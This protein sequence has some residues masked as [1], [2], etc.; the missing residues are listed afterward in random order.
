MTP[1]NANVNEFKE[2][3]GELQGNLLLIRHQIKSRQRRIDFSSLQETIT[4]ISTKVLEIEQ[5]HEALNNKGWCPTISKTFYWIAGWQ[6]VDQAAG[7]YD[8]FDEVTKTSEC[9]M[10]LLKFACISDEARLAYCSPDPTPKI[11]TLSIGILASIGTLY[12]SYQS[13]K[14][15]DRLMTSMAKDVRRTS[16]GQERFLSFMESL[17]TFQDQPSRNQFKSSALQLRT[18][19]EDKYLQKLGPIEEL[20][21]SMIAMQDDGDINSQLGKLKKYNSNRIRRRKTRRRGEKGLTKSN[22]FDRTWADLTSTFDGLDL[23]YIY[24]EGKYYCKNGEVRKTPP[25][26]E[27]SETVVLELE[28]IN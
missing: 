22:S 26:A 10:S 25:T 20:A 1:L 9:V 19:R 14:D 3:Q 12:T 16:D 6:L 27:E 18:L 13:E 15:S 2:L 5:Q 28:K 21:S 17:A 4:K 11:I 24:H 7:L 8:F 23:Q